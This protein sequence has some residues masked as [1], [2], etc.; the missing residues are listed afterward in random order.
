MAQFVAL[1]TQ[2][3]VLDQ[4]ALAVGTN[5]AEL[6]KLATAEAQKLNDEQEGFGEGWSAVVIPVEQPR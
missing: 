3:M 6:E 2:G 5:Q 4:K 1:V